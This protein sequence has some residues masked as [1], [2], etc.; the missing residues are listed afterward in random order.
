[1]T[2][3]QTTELKGQL[4]YVTTTTDKPKKKTQKEGDKHR[5]VS[6]NHT[7]PDATAVI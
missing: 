1:M 2:P 7:S 5:Y 6:I 4:S 3:S